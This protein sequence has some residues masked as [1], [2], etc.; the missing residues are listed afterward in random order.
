MRLLVAADRWTQL[1]HW[2]AYFC[3]CRYWLLSAVR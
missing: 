3:V 2:L 1:T